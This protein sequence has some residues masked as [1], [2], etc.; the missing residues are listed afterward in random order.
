MDPTIVRDYLRYWQGVISAHSRRNPDDATLA[1]YT[2]GSALNRVVSAVNDNRHRGYY[3]RGTVRHQPTVVS[4][5]DTTA[6]IQDCADISN[7]TVYSTR[8]GRAVPLGAAV[9]RRRSTYTLAHRDDHWVVM[10]A[11]D[12]DAC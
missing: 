2:G 10:A 1:E 9:P 7:W 11:E 6:T 3:R 5:T 4:A 12:G 8:T